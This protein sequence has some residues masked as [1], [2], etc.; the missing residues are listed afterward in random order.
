MEEFPKTLR[1]EYERRTWRLIE[2]ENKIYS[3]IL[4][5][6]MG[7]SFDKEFENI[8]KVDGEQGF[9]I[10]KDNKLATMVLFNKL[11]ITVRKY[12]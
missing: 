9:Y 10:I 4:I 1:P 12:R 11:N 8:I 6:D 2:D 7:R 3:N 5:I